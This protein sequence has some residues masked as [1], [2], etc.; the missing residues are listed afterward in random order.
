VSLELIEA[1]VDRGVVVRPPRPGVA[2]QA[3]LDPS[4]GVRDSFAAAVSSR[5]ENGEVVLDC[6]LEIKAPFNPTSAT[7]QVAALLKSYGITTATSD[8]YAAEWPAEA[9]RKCGITLRA[10]DRDRSAIYADALPLFTSGRA[11]L[12]DNARL[13]N[14]FASLER[15]TTSLGPDKIDHGPGGRDDLANAA[16]LSMVLA[17][18][19]KKPMTFFYV[20]EVN[21]GGAGAYY[22]SFDGG[23]SGRPGGEPL[24]SN[25]QQRRAHVY[26]LNN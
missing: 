20:P 26:S 23:G 18:S 3:G 5:G 12:L 9:F 2:Y 1:A 11:R 4:G 8:R 7:E 17:A 6:L 14:Q 15:K 22:R 10:S 19:Q 16:A 21:H 13:V 25:E 24:A